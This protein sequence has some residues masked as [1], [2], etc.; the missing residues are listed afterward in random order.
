MTLFI[1]GIIIAYLLGSVN[2]AI[3]ISKIFKLPDPRKQGSGNPGATNILRSAGRNKAMLVLLGDGLK[4]FIAVYL[5]KMLGFSGI[6]LA[7]AA[8]AA[9]LGH[10]YPVFFKFK[11]G[12]GV[13]TALG[14]ILGMSLLTGVLA[15]AIWVGMIYLIAYVSAASMIALMLVP[16]IFVLTG[17]VVYI[18][19]TL[20]M[21]ILIII[22]HK[23]NI[24]RLK[25]GTESKFEFKKRPP[26]G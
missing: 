11:G 9:V 22:K 26:H 24:S 18:L 3:L 14:G 7:W 6:P 15:I 21:V 25:A 20:I 8:L 12:K 23:D 19:P 17:N 2:C 10:M 13:A 4:G 1:I 5:I 16:V